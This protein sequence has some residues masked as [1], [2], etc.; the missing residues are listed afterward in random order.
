VAGKTT[1]LQILQALL[2]KNAEKVSLLGRV[3]RAAAELESM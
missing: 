3:W 1:P 2:R